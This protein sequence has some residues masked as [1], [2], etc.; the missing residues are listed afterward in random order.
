MEVSRYTFFEALRADFLLFSR[1]GFFP[2]T[3]ATSR[4]FVGGEVA[5]AS[6]MESRMPVT[7]LTAA[8]AATS[9]V[10]NE[11]DVFS[12]LDIFSNFFG[13]GVFSELDLSESECRVEK[14]TRL[15]A[16]YSSSKKDKLGFL[17][18]SVCSEDVSEAGGAE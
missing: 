8:E 13:L 17:G 2:L 1:I 16:T 3:T 11:L 6:W 18:R 15:P 10:E 12:E 7:L 5:R 14:G 4:T 9:D